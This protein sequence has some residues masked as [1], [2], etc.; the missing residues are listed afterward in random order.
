MRN[1]SRITNYYNRQEAWQDWL[2][3]AKQAHMAS[4]HD[5]VKKYTPK[6]NSGWRTIDKKIGLLRAALQAANI[7]CTRR[8]EGSNAPNIFNP[9]ADSTATVLSKPAPR[10]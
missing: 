6:N 4:R 10:G 1:L 8:G 5:L 9:E 3:L 7:T 2:H